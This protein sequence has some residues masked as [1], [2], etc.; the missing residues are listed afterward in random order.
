MMIDPRIDASAIANIM[1][2]V[3]IGLGVILAYFV[4]IR[5]LRQQAEVKK[6]LISIEDRTFFSKMSKDEEW[7]VKLEKSIADLND[8]LTDREYEFRSVNHLLV[9]SENN[10]I[11]L[12][13]TSAAT[14]SA[15]LRA[16]NIKDSPVE[17]DLIFVLTPFENR[18]ETTYAAVVEA[19]VSWNVRVLRGDEEEIN[20]NILAHIVSLISR[21]NIVI[22]NVSTRNPNV[23]Y[24]LGIAQAL[25]KKVV[26]IARSID[27]VPFDLKHQ[28]IL[29]YRTRSD[30]ISK[31]RDS[32]GS[33]IISSFK[34]EEE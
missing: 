15:F 18:E 34:G 31:L 29:L 21:A 22:A 20:S 17:K 32:V 24:E 28:R 30:L 1:I 8:R 3:S 13:A 10:P 11:P 4:A 26:M 2:A 16:L 27:D 19:F 14:P 9:D 5:V 12:E 33:I 6:A 25:G 7:R 23:M